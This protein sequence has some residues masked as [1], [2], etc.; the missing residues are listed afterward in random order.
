VLSPSRQSSK[1]KEKDPDQYGN[2]ATN[3]LQIYPLLGSGLDLVRW[4]KEN[5]HQHL[6]GGKGEEGGKKKRSLF[7]GGGEK[8]KEETSLF[9]AH[10]TDRAAGALGSR[11]ERRRGRRQSPVHYMKRGGE[12]SSPYLRSRKREKA[13]FAE[14]LERTVKNTCLIP[15]GSRKDRRGRKRKG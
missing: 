1:K 9:R 13:S 2:D 5:K 15:G 3:S 10:G 12:S 11:G 8:G 14:G 6:G 4:K 7:Y